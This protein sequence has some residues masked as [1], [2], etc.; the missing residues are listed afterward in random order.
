MPTTISRSGGGAHART[1]AQQIEEHNRRTGGH[2][3]VIA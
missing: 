3:R 2:R 1:S